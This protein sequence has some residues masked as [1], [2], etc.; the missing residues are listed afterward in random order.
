MYRSILY[1]SQEE[2]AFINLCIIVSSFFFRTY[3]NIENEEEATEDHNDDDDEDNSNT[4]EK[5][6]PSPSVSASSTDS[7]RKRSNTSDLCE[8]LTRFIASRDKSYREGTTKKK[9]LA[10]FFEDIAE[11][12]IKFPE[13]DQAEIKREIFNLVN[14]KE[15]ELL[16]QKQSVPHQ[17]QQNILSP[18]VYHSQYSPKVFFPTEPP[19]TSQSSHGYFSQ[20]F[21]H[22]P[23]NLSLN[24]PNSLYPPAE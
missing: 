23:K 20:A 1:N 22:V 10:V 14:K 11:T 21:S 9:Q 4:R 6:T 17:Y 3:T 7:K 2:S 16:R 12:M 5:H 8:T 18:A 13:V 15:I 19:T 24:H